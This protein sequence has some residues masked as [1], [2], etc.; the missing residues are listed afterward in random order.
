MQKRTLG[1]S[2]LEVSAL[3]LGCMGMST[4][5]G[6]VPDKQEMISLL[7]AAVDRGHQIDP[8]VLGD[9]DRRHVQMP[10]LVRACD[11][12]EPG[13]PSAI[14]PPAALD[15][16]ALAHDPQHA[17][18]VDRP[19]E[20]ARDERCDHPVAVGLVGLRDRDDRRLDAIGRRR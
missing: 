1:T 5:Y 12:E 13:P 18:A 9:P 16:A 10:E 11:P 2:G 15:Q 17:L 14:Q 8:A 7:R 6:R 4:S 3:G 20:L 19:P